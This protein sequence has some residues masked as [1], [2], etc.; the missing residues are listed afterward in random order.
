MA[1]RSAV[2]RFPWSESGGAGVTIPI[3]ILLALKR[4]RAKA[5][6]Y[7]TTI[8]C[9]EISIA[10]M[11]QPRTSYPT[12]AAKDFVIPKPRLG[13][14]FIWPSDKAGI[15]LKVASRPFPCVADHLPASEGTITC[16]QRINRNTSQRS[17]IKIRMLQR[18]RIIAPGKRALVL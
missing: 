17:P 10:F 18:R 11:D 2:I 8:G 16:R 12:T 1:Q 13:I 15:W 3:L 9:V 4:T 5:R 6:P 7:V 14:F